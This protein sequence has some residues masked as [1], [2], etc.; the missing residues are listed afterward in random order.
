[1]LNI[2]D[3]NEIFLRW[4]LLTFEMTREDCNYQNKKKYK[5]Y[6]VPFNEV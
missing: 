1:M 3:E 2:V 4:H 5:F 6:A